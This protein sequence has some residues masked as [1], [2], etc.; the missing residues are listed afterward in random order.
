MGSSQ[1]MVAMA[2]RDHD[3]LVDRLAAA[4]KAVAVLEAEQSRAYRF[5]VAVRKAA[6]KVYGVEPVA[7]S[8]HSSEFTCNRCA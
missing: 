2:E 1:R 7:C 6:D 5:L 3:G 8:E 4:R